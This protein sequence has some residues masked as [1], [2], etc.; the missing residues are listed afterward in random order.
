MAHLADYARN[1]LKDI[2]NDYKNHP[3]SND[4][5]QDGVCLCVVS[6]PKVGEVGWG[7]DEKVCPPDNA[8]RR[9]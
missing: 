5:W 3:N 7:R 6:K 1:Y 2:R 4:H 9:G 8:I